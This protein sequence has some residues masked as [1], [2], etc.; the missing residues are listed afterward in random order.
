MKHLYQRLLAVCCA[1]SMLFSA[2]GSASTGQT[3]QDSSQ[4]AMG[5]YLEEERTLPDKVGMNRFLVPGTDGSLELLAGSSDAS[6]IGTW[7]LY[8]SQDGG[9]SWTQED[10][11]WLEELGEDTMISGYGVREDG[12]RQLRY[13]TYSQE[14]IDALT[15]FYDSGAEDESL[16]PEEPPYYDWTIA[17]DGTSSGPKEVTDPYTGGTAPIT[18]ADD[19]SWFVMDYTH[20][21]HYGTDGKLINTVE[22]TGM[23]SNNSCIALGDRLYIGNSDGVN[24]YDIATGEKLSNEA[25]DSLRP[26]AEDMATMVFSYENNAAHVA[27]SAD[28]SSLC[29]ADPNGIYQMKQGGTVVEKLLDGAL[30]SLNMPSLT[31]EAF[32]PVGEEEFVILLNDGKNTSLMGYT[33]SPD[34]P[35]VPQT[36][37]EV[38]GLE[39]NKTVRQ[40]MSL[41]QRQHPDVQVNY[42]VASDAEGTTTSDQLRTLSTELLS[43]KGPDIL[44]L[45][46]MPMDSYREKGVLMDLTEILAQCEPLLENV[47]AA[48]R[49]EN[50]TW[51]VPARFS[52]PYLMAPS[53]VAGEVDTF[54]GLVQAAQ[55]GQASGTYPT[56]ALINQSPLAM[57]NFFSHT[58][59]GAWVQ[60]GTVQEE[61]LSQFL[62]AI[63]A[64]QKPASSSAEEEYYANALEDASWGALEW[65]YQKTMFN[66]GLVQSWRDMAT[67]EAARKQRG[68]GVIQPMQGQMG[69]TFC[70]QAT[71][72]INNNSS[73][74]ELAGQFVQLLLSQEVQKNN[75]TD[76]FAVNQQAFEESSW[77]PYSEFDDGYSIGSSDEDGS[78]LM[79]LQVKWPD[80][81][82]ME[83][84]AQQITAITT[85]CVPDQTVLDLIWEAAQPYF[86]GSIDC[87]TAVEAVQRKLQLVL[88]E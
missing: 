61:A 72:G 59:A 64:L 47:S 71:V 33:Y 57:L 2:C 19:G 29:F 56:G 40:A 84:F 80:K 24:E 5:R 15:S 51:A 9:R 14:Y 48:F 45:D 3:S 10:T 25:L 62:E 70:P 46:G 17:P 55:E 79:L 63:A 81:A 76:G 74:K 1:C 7:N 69:A 8:R 83:A 36:K 12:T 4:T 39:E 13:V 49:D 32:V 60:D 65:S 22:F 34:T 37:L 85:P 87:T 18:F 50:G 28:G 38:F 78:N 86:D 30:T 23:S 44:L 68:D 88:A 52:V 54:G 58:C 26:K 67:M 31:L 82:T 16:A 43:G 27:A 41:F 35:T 20:V 66:T 6:M 75:F 11:P 73:Q 77:N 42:T 53:A 21:D